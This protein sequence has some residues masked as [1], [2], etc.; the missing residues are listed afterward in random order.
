MSPA[1]S[2]TRKPARAAV[3]FPNRGQMIKHMVYTCRS[4]L[5]NHDR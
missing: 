4:R 3:T 5:V 2:T 1:I